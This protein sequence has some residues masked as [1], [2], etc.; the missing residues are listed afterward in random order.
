M[1]MMKLILIIVFAVIILLAINMNKSTN[2]E[3][4]TAYDNSD[5][6]YNCLVDVEKYSRISRDQLIDMMGVPSKFSETNKTN[7]YTYEN[8]NYNLE[9]EVYDNKVVICSIELSD[10]SNLFDPF[11]TFGIIPGSNMI[12]ASTIDSLLFYKS[13]NDKVARVKCFLNEDG[14]INYMIVT[15]DLRLY[16]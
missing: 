10:T 11:G 7:I 3:V 14:S 4:E 1:K 8:K 5:I 15:Y 16:E 13:V 6:K 12:N 2:A 9:F